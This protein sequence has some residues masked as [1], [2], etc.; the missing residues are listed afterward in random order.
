MSR[1][2]VDSRGAEDGDTGGDSSASSLSRAHDIE[3][4]L[5]SLVA[6]CAEPVPL[7][8]E[9]TAADIGTP[10]ATAS[11]ARA[12]LRHLLD[13]RPD[14]IAEQLRRE[15]TE[16]DWLTRCRIRMAGM[17]VRGDTDWVRV[18]DVVT[19]R[20]EYRERWRVAS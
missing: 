16:N 4:Y 3:H 7:L 15:L 1:A 11:I 8:D 6:R 17:D 18:V 14:T 2:P 19:A 5:R 9:L 12:A 20:R 10:R 13:G